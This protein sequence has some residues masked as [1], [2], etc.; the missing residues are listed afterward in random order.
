V[1]KYPNELDIIRI[2]TDI[3]GQ[4]GVG[5]STL[6]DDVA[7]A[8]TSHSRLVI[9]CDMLVG[10]TDVPEGMTYKQA[11]RKS[12]VSCISDFAAK[13][14]APNAIMVSL[15][16]PKGTTFRKARELAYGIKDVCDKF[17][18]KFLGGDTNETGDLIIDCVMIGYAGSI[19]ERK[20]AHVGDLVAVSGPLGTLVLVS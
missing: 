7:Q 20:G 10:M 6:G 2:F 9:K 1:T 14:V 18:I 3:L 19:L 12:V 13:G 5:Y 17:E 8:P 4:P 15:G 11:G 16:L